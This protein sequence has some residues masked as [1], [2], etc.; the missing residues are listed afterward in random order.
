MRNSN[1]EPL[2]GISVAAR[3]IGISPRVLRSYEEADLIYPY[4]TEGN[5]RLY[6]ERDIRKLRVIHY[7]NKEKEVNLTGIKVILDLLDNINSAVFYEREEKNVNKK[8]TTDV[9]VN[10]EEVLDKIREFAPELLTKKKE[11]KK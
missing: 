2:F 6:S 4:R 1:K 5:T 10:G 3:L 7:L 8:Q 11:S 9:G